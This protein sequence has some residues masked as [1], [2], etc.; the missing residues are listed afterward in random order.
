MADIAIEI[1]FALRETLAFPGY[2]YVL[3]SPRFDELTRALTEIESKCKFGN[4]IMD[5]RFQIAQIQG[6]ANRTQAQ[7]NPVLS[8]LETI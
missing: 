3:D 7:R 8:F 6:E 5:H 1:R 4:Q 2:R